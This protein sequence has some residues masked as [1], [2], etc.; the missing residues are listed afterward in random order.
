LQEIPTET[1]EQ[2]T[3]SQCYKCIHVTVKDEGKVVRQ[4]TVT[5]SHTVVYDSDN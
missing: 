2:D 1:E 4:L 5:L 3:S